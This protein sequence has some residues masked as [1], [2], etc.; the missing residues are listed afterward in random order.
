MGGINDDQGFP[1]IKKKSVA[2]NLRKPLMTDA[3]L[4]TFF[5]ESALAQKIREAV[6]IRFDTAAQ[7]LTPTLQT[8]TTGQ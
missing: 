4:E 3:L 5:I 7:R 2:P 6:L 8:N 1:S